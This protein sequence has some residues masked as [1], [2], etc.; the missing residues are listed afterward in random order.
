MKKEKNGA[1]I[2]PVICINNKRTITV[3]I[4]QTVNMSSLLFSFIGIPSSTE[5]CKRPYVPFL[6]VNIL[7]YMYIIKNI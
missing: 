4:K 1:Q 3:E 2:A 7:M 5:Y 6:Q